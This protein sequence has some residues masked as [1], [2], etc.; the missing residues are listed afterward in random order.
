MELGGRLKYFADLGNSVK[1][2]FVVSK[3]IN[4][5]LICENAKHIFKSYKGYL[6]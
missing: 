2:F 4:S 3:I 5:Y 6:L 1:K